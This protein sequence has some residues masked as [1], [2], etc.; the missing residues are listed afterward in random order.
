MSKPNGFKLKGTGPVSF[1]LGCD[2]FRDEDGTLCFG[3][4]R[5]IDRMGDQ[6]KK[7]FGTAPPQKASSPLEKNDHPELD[8]SPLLDVD[9]I[10]KYQSLIGALQWAIT[11]G[12]FD[13]AT[14]VMTMSG[15]RVAPRQGHLERVKRICGYLTKFQSAAIWVRT[16]RKS[17]V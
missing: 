6:Y 5:Y 15:F 13:L 14:A 4:R 10:A 16:D 9:D 8:D 17:V 7:L 1:H 11:L 12:R 3:P 2:F